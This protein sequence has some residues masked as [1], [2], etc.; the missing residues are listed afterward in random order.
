MKNILVG[1]ISILFLAGPAMAAFLSESDEPA[2]IISVSVTM[3][4][5][6]VGLIGTAKIFRAMNIRKSL[7]GLNNGSNVK[8]NTK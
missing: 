3:M 6:G 4:F 1:F 5:L 8:K 7:D 2:M